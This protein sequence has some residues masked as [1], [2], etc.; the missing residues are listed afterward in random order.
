MAIW[1]AKM[2]ETVSGGVAWNSHHIETDG[3]DTG[4][5]F[6]LVEAQ[7]LVLHGFNRAVFTGR[8][9][10]TREAT[11]IARCHGAA[12]FHGIGEQH[13]SGNGAMG[14]AAL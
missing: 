9:E 6:E 7:R 8:N 13:E 10:R 14:T 1:S 5:R 11:D 2:A 3:A 4:H 12:F